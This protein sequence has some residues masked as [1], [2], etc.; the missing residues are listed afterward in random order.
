MVIIIFGHEPKSNFK[1]IE[2]FR[3]D[4]EIYVEIQHSKPYYIQIT[5][6]E[7]KNIIAID[8]PGGP[9]I[10]VNDIYNSYKL[11]SLSLNNNKIIGIFKK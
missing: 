2:I 3:K 11:I 8:G 10:R 5:Y 6:D 9:C 7:N 1:F 4:K